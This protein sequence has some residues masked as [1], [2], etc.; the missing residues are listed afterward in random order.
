[1]Q[2]RHAKAM[3]ENCSKIPMIIS[4]SELSK[5]RFLISPKERFIMRKKNDMKRSF[6]SE[7]KSLFDKKSM[8]KTLSN[9]II[10]TM[11]KTLSI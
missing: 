7:K 11:E 2:K 5:K 8:K 6:D 4:A 10:E 1:M 9:K 3:N